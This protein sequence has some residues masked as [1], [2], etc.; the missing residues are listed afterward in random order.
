VNRGSVAAFDSLV[1][2]SGG[3]ATRFHQQRQRGFMALAA[4]ELT[5]TAQCV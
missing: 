1:I 2:S 4:S 3:A 5:E